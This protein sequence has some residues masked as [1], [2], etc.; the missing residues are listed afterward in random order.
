[1]ETKKAAGSGLLP[2]EDF[3]SLML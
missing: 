3:N 1:M 2:Y